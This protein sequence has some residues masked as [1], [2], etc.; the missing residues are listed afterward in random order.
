MIRE[1][2]SNVHPYKCKKIIKLTFDRNVS[3][4][5]WADWDAY[6]RRKQQK[7][8]RK[9]DKNFIEEKNR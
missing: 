8:F 9:E 5:N 6:L 2:K 3:G 7:C 4:K 1:D